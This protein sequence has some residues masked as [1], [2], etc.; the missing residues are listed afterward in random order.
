MKKLDEVL[1]NYD[2]YATFL[3]DR[4]GSRLCEF[5]TN[6]QAEKIGFKF[7]EDYINEPKKWTEEN[8]VKQLKSDVEFGWS[9]CVNKRGISAE[10]MYEVVKSWCIVLENG[11][12]ET[13]YG[14]YGDEFFKA[15]DAEYNFG[16]T[17]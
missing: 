6:E 4:F 8:V 12:E 14:W 7:K 15:I 11:L 13:S 9:K 17:V 1:N 16:V 3:D 2:K 5:L 10:L